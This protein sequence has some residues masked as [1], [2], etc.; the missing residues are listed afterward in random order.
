M[1]LC[2]TRSLGR[3]WW[4][5]SYTF[6]SLRCDCILDRNDIDSYGTDVSLYYKGFTGPTDGYYP[7][8]VGGG[9][10]LGYPLSVIW[11]CSWVGDRTTHPSRGG[12]F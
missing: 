8:P 12:G 5:W 10:R 6:D 4:V 2:W 11:A 1:I 3:R 9:D 7:R